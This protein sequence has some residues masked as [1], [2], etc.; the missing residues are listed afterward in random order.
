MGSNNSTLSLAPPAR[1]TRVIVADPYPVI[2]LG[3]R[4]MVE[5]DPRFQVVA[6]VSTMRSFWQGLAAVRP[7]VALLDWYMASQ[8]LDMTN[9]LLRSVPHPTSVIFLTGSENTPQEQDMLRWGGEAFLS[10]RCSAEKL[11][12]A[13]SMACK[14][15]VAYEPAAAKPRPVKAFPA[16]S[17]TDPV[18][19]IKQLTKRERQLLPLVCSGLKNKEI[20]RELDISESTVWHHL[21]AVFT[22]LQVTDRMGLAAFAYSHRLVYPATQFPPGS[23]LSSRGTVA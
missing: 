1:R 12:K 3:V 22:K 20:A 23:D 10:K 19:R 13:V 8:D 5:D 9:A 18:Q 17:V 14:E 11:R 15:P 21:T 16:P 2:L 7:E 6:E 4:K